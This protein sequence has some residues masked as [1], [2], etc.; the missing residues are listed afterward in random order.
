M[1]MIAFLRGQKIRF[2]H[3][4]SGEAS[5]KVLT[6]KFKSNICETLKKHSFWV[7]LVTTAAVKKSGKIPAFLFPRQCVIRSAITMTEL[8]GQESSLFTH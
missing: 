5:E 6:A 2:S 3:H 7:G 8:T 1:E 4:G